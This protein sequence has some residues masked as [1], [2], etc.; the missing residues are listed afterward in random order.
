MTNSDSTN[1][2]SRRTPLGPAFGFTFINS[3]GTYVVTSSGLYF[4]TQQGYGFSETQNYLLGV[5]LGIT[6]IVGAKLAS[7][8]Q[9]SL[10]RVIPGFSH[11]G[12]LVVLMVAMAA[13]CLVPQAAEWLTGST[14]AARSS[15]PIWTI[16]LIYSP[17]MGILW[18]IVESYISGGR[19]GANLRN[20]MGSWNVVWSAAGVLATFA[21]APLV[22]K[23]PALAVLL[24]SGAHLLAMLTVAPFPAEPAEHIEGEHE[25]HPPVFARLLITFRLLLPMAYVASAAIGPYLPFAGEKL[26]LS[27]GTQAMLPAAWLIPR[28]AMFYVMQRWQGWHGRWYIAVGSGVLLVLSFGVTICAPLLG[29]RFDLIALLA[30]LAGF[31]AAMAVIYSAAIYYAMEVGKTEV[32]AGGTHEALIGV[33]YTIGPSF[34]LFA[35]LAAT[36]GYLD[37]ILVQPVVLGAVLALSV[38]TALLVAHRVRRQMRHG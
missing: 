10:H 15:W 21:V 37:P 2:T 18:P 28:V 17:L 20:T 36:G 35:T 24:V 12:L 11:R 13:L 25:P 1:S 5:L 22:G 4:L 32:D 26:S 29:E 23:D 14:T 6:Y 38:A 31:G 30:G 27:G 19:S 16:V 3:I 9:T 7:R 33:G 34:G 8:A